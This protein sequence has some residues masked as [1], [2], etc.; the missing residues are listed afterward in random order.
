MILP[1]ISPTSEPP[2]TILRLSI[3]WWQ[4]Q[5][6]ALTL[7]IL[8]CHLIILKWDKKKY[9]FVRL[10]FWLGALRARIRSCL[11]V[12]Y[13]F[14]YNDILKLVFLHC[15]GRTHIVSRDNAMDIF[16]LSLTYKARA[17]DSKWNPDTNFNQNTENL[18]VFLLK[19]SLSSLKNHTLSL[20]NWGRKLYHHTDST[21]EP[22]FFY[23]DIFWLWKSF[24]KIH[25]LNIKGNIS[26]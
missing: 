24:L 7:Y 13:F 4:L 12:N 14:F 16:T 2:L 25:L 6:M 11:K 20:L 23:K 17:S 3:I 1:Q 18:D 26:C 8:L 22:W 19:L 21:N 15:P 5:W 9:R 10:T